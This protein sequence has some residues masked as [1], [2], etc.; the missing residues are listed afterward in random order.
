MVAGGRWVLCGAPDG[1]WSHARDPPWGWGLSV[2]FLAGCGALWGPWWGVGPCEGSPRGEGG[3]L[4]WPSRVWRGPLWGGGGSLWGT[5]AGRGAVWGPFW[6]VGPR[7][8]SPVGK[9][10]LCGVV[11]KDPGRCGAGWGLA[12]RAQWGARGRHRPVEACALPAALRSRT[13]SWTGASSSS[14]RA[15]P[16]PGMWTRCCLPRTRASW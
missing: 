15:L 16:S 13:R 10:T 9:G 11:H 4:G 1:V 14:C 6:G 3:S 5:L 12:G 7:E 8:G 2:G